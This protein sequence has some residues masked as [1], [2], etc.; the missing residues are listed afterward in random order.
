MMLEEFASYDRF[1]ETITGVILEL[2]EQAVSEVNLNLLLS[3]M[4]LISDV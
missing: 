4:C 3:A 2:E 1:P